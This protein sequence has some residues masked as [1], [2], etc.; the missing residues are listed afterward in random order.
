MKIRVIQVTKINLKISQAAA[1]QGQLASS[2][3]GIPTLDSSAQGITALS[4]S[5]SYYQSFQQPRIKSHIL[6]LY[7]TPAQGT[8]MASHPGMVP[9]VSPYPA[10][11][12]LANI[13]GVDWSALG[14]SLPAMYT[15]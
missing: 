3:A 13:P 4:F 11:Y 2:P 7:D 5:L 6:S 1:A 8:S 9:G 12:S 15:L 14:Y 10:G